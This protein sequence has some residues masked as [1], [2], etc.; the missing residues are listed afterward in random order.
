M[1]KKLF[2]IIYALL[3]MIFSYNVSAS[4]TSDISIVYCKFQRTVLRLGDDIPVVARIWNNNLNDSEVKIE[5]KLLENLTLSEGSLSSTSIMPLLSYT[6]IRWAVQAGQTGNILLEVNII[7]GPG[8][9]VK[10][11]I[12]GT[13]TDQYWKQ[14]EFL[15]SAWSPPSNMQLAYDY[16]KAANLNFNLMI[17]SPFGT[18]VNLVKSNK[19]KCYAVI[20]EVIPDYISKLYGSDGTP[21]EITAQDLALMDP[22]IKAY[23]ADPAVDGYSIID[24]PGA[25]RFANI[26]KVVAYL[27][28]KDPSKLAYINAF[29]TYA[30]AEQLNT[31]T[32]SEY[33][34]RFMDEVKPEMLS[35]DHYHFFTGSDGEDYFNNLGIIRDFALQY[36]VPYTNIIQLIGTELVYSPKAPALGWRTPTPAEHRFL[37]YTSLAYGYTGIVWFHWQNMWGLTGFVAAKKA[38]MYATVTQ[39][40]KEINNIGVELLKLKSVGAYHVKNIPTGAQSLPAGEIVKGISGNQSYIAG[41]FKDALQADYF[42]IMN[43]DYNSDSQTTISLKDKLSKLEYF[44]ADNNT[45]VNVTGFTSSNAGSEFSMMIAAGNGI[46]FR[47]TWNTVDAGE[48]LVSDKSEY[49]RNYPNP[50]NTNTT[51]EYS[52]ND[53]QLVE[54]S[55][56]NIIGER[57]LTFEKEYRTKGIYTVNFDASNLP[58][59]VF[60]MTL[61]S[62]IGIRTE[63]MIYSR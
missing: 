10:T 1:K 36:D 61:K 34:S 48:S 16:Y 58:P 12:S 2:L 60:F 54:L 56:Y 27:K 6:E 21:P 47:P 22:T 50:F 62:D 4:E 14:K 24:E 41:I 42:M 49:L 38:E 26:S 18:G 55:I 52:I 7:A 35:Y 20:T 3:A 5:L 44:N 57:V 32:Y 63:R 39:L 33:I 13:V 30:T 11:Q 51:I 45:W 19:M 23:K 31:S 8:D 46:L 15:L 59:G 25:S 40:D 9:T 53:D 17:S 28:E 37:V 29:P 43:K